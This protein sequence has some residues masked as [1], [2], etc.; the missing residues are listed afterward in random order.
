MLVTA[1]ALPVIVLFSGV[2][3][4]KKDANIFFHWIFE[5][6]YVKHAGDSTLAALMGYNRSRLNCG[7]QFYCH[8]EKPKK[9]IDSLELE[10]EIGYLK[11]FYLVIFLTFFRSVAF[12][13]INYRLKH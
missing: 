8:Y 7:E 4:I 1:V 5:L 6:C 3:I 11:I 12:Y 2:A 10:D 13:M 9:L